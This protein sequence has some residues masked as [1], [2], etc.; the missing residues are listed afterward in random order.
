MTDFMQWAE[1][2]GNL[3]D[4]LADARSGQGDGASTS[5]DVTPS[6][7]DLTK[8]SSDARRA[9]GCLLGGAVGDALGAR[10]EFMSWE[11]IRRGF[12][13]W[14]IRSMAPAYGRRGAITDD[15]Q[16]MLFTAEGLLRALVRM[17]DNGSCHIPAVLHHALQRW[18]IP[19]ALSRN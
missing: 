6:A 2:D 11:E 17:R 8:L 12:G 18:L 10:V 1:R 19:R 13:E 16:M 3:V 4:D 9:V 15:T 14:G 7:P 5:A